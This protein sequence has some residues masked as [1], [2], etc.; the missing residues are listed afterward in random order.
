MNSGNKKLFSAA[1]KVVT[2][3]YPE[4]APEVLPMHMMEWSQMIDRERGQQQS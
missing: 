3:Y 1:K 2:L 4:L